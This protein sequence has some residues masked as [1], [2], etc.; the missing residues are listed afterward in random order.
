MILSP[1]IRQCSPRD[2]PILVDLG[3]TTFWAA[4]G[5][6]MDHDQLDSYINRAFTLDRIEDELKDP[7]STFFLA[8]INGS[9][10]GYAKLR[11]ESQ[12]DFLIHANPV[13]LER[14]YA[15][16]NYIGRGI[17]RILMKSV[18]EKARSDQR[19][20][21]WL[22]VWQHNARAIRFYEKWGF[23]RVGEQTFTV[24]TDVQRDVVFELAL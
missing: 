2:A 3:R 5:D 18:L 23:K 1:T 20:S 16:P 15:E 19:G 4:Y 8:E 6:L 10:I 9:P 24:G 22:G 12:P 11:A 7:H 17:G 21:I 14:I 13:E